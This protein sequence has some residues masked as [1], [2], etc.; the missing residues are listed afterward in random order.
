MRI[1]I[2]LC[3]ALLASV[4][5]VQA[6]PIIIGNNSSID[7]SKLDT[8]GSKSEF[9]VESKNIKDMISGEITY[10]ITP[11]EWNDTEM[12]D[13]QQRY[14]VNP[15]QL[16]LAAFD[17]ASSQLQTQNE[18]HTKKDKTERTPEEIAEI[19]STRNGSQLLYLYI[20]EF[21]SAENSQNIAL[22]LMEDRQDWLEEQ[23][24]IAIPKA[25]HDENL[26]TLGL[27]KPLYRDGY[28]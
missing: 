28:R 10:L 25:V 26:V 21:E 16:V 20:S 11:L 12:A 22:F 17:D 14:G 9:K 18:A 6:E 1:I 24:L 23:G 15:H 2:T 8:E 19:F 4:Q 3:L 27:K 13:Y 7:F 5:L